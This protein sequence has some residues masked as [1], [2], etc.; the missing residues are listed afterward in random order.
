MME[1]KCFFEKIVNVRTVGN[2]SSKIIT[3]P[4]DL[5]TALKAIHGE[6][7][8]INVK[9][10]K[11]GKVEFEAIR[12]V[13]KPDTTSSGVMAIPK[14]VIDSIENEFDQ[15]WLR[16]WPNGKIEIVPVIRK[17]EKNKGE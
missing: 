1:E 12:K 16:A 13:Y 8:E 7:D 15:V 3:I 17:E 5:W 2:S 6:F 14:P 10:W 11:D 9:A 4:K